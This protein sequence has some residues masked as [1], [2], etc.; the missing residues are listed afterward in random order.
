MTFDPVVCPLASM[1]P[2]PRDN[3][4]AE[5]ETVHPLLPNTSPSNDRDMLSDGWFAVDVPLNTAR[6]R[7]RLL[8]GGPLGVQFVLVSKFVPVAP[9]HEKSAA[10][11]CCPDT[12]AVISN[13]ATA[14]ERCRE[15]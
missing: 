8:A 10:L 1:P 13:P 2:V 4:K 12:K 11:T 7:V 9:V 3:T 6:S 15:D 5:P 14:V